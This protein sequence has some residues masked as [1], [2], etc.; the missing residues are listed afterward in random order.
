MSMFLK[1]CDRHKRKRQAFDEGQNAAT[2]GPVVENG[3][4]HSKI[5]SDITNLTE[6]EFTFFPE[7][8]FPSN[9][10][11]DSAIPPS[12]DM[13]KK[14]KIE[15]S[16][17]LDNLPT[18]V[19]RSPAMI[20]RFGIIPEYHKTGGKYR[21]KDSSGGEKKPLGAEQAFKMTNK[22]VANILARVGFEGGSES[23]VEVFSEILSTRICKLGR[24]LKLLSDSYKKQFSSIELL[25]MFLQTAGYSNLGTLSEFIK[26]GNKGFTQQAHQN[27]RIMQPQQQNLLLQ[28]H[29]Q[30]QRQVQHMQQMQMLHPQNLA[31]Q[32]QLQQ[33]QLLRR[34][35]MSTPRGSM[36]I[37][38]K[39][40]QPMVDVKLENVMES[41][42]ESMFNSLS[43]QQQLQ[44]RQQMAMSNQHAQSGQQFKQMA[45]VQLPQ[46]QAQN[47]YGMRTQPVKV[48]AFHELMG[49]DSSI[50]HDSDPNKLTSSQQ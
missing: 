32:Q 11:P 42:M 17:V 33:Q 1:L 50:K 16:E 36:V 21:G 28:A 15:V 30:L 27:V 35:Q 24:I 29:Q 46:L 31:F 47:A 22:V 2:R 26:D 37:M 5:A 14:Q 13:E 40:Q 38:D 49:G 41:P 8:M 25:K 20:E 39:D 18:V 19:S 12:N 10:V 44:L 6:E 4:V 43:K 45:N 3:S 48:E 23:S 7:M 9:C 34:R